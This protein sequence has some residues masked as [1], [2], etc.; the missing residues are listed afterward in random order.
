[1]TLFDRSAAM[2]KLARSRVT[3]ELASRVESIRGEFLATPFEAEKYDLI[4]CLGVLP[5]VEVSLA[6][7]RKIS[8]LVKP[9]GTLITDCTD[10]NHV[11]SRLRNW[12]RAVMGL[13]KPPKVWPYQR[14]SAACLVEYESC[15]LKVQRSYHYCLP[16]PLIERLASDEFHRRM[17]YYIFGKPPSNR[18]AWLGNEGI[19]CLK[20]IDASGMCPN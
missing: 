6:F 16:P 17:I 15:G 4:V 20:R 8:S 3:Q 10:A 12:H 11:V 19:Y 14:S 13:I 5:Y 9:G 1:L 2:L 7:I 18:N